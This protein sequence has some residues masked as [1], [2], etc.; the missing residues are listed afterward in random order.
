LVIPKDA[1]QNNLVEVIL[2]EF[3]GKT[4]AKDKAILKTSVKNLQKDGADAILLACTEFPIILKQQDLNI[5]LIDCNEVYAQK[6]AQ[7]SNDL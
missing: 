7:L 3:S 1:D 4:S 6:T 2:N 5:P